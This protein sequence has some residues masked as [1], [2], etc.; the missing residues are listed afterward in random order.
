MTLPTP[1]GPGDVIAEL[2]TKWNPTTY[3]IAKPKFKEIV[4][5]PAAGNEWFNMPIPSFPYIVVQWNGADFPFEALDKDEQIDNDFEIILI[6][7]TKT[8]C[9]RLL[10]AVRTILSEK[11]VTSGEWHIESFR[12]RL[13]ETQNPFYAYICKMKETLW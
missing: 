6:G 12:P 7:K 8:D 9:D 10:F 5:V 13:S 3:E 11:D 2:S 1:S 4:G